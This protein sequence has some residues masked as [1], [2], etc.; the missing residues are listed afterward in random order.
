MALFLTRLRAL[1]TLLLVVFGACKSRVTEVSRV[2]LGC[3]RE[4]RSIASG[5]SPAEPNRWPVF[6]NRSLE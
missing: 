1:A 4:I 3:Y 5:R 2:L 6:R